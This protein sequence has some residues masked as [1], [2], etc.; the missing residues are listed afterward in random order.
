MSKA[1]K[2]PAGNVDIFID[3]QVTVALMEKI[4]KVVRERCGD[5]ATIGVEGQ[6]SIRIMGKELLP[7]EE[8]E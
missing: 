7:R 4:C 5:Q 2:W 6:Q 1:K 3:G 8:G